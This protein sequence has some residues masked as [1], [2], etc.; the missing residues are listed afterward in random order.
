MT[1]L[2][3]SETIR[4]LTRGERKKYLVTYDEM[5]FEMGV[6]RSGAYEGH[7]H[8]RFYDIIYSPEGVRCRCSNGR[9]MEG[10][11]VVV[12]PR[13]YLG[14]THAADFFFLKFCPDSA[15]LTLP[16]KVLEPLTAG[17]VLTYQDEA[18]LVFPWCPFEGHAI[19]TASLRMSGIVL[20]VEM[21]SDYTIE[22]LR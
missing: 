13:T 19:T 12:P 9:Q 10:R 4:L 8:L 5:G 20:K 1:S 21:G 3:I 17:S 18:D 16:E 6:G 11:L 22:V 7:S 2:S 14:T 15:K